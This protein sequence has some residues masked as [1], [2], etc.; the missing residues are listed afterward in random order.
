MT[1]NEDSATVKLL[2]DYQDSKRRVASLT[3][4]L[5]CKI[6]NIR[7][8]LD[9]FDRDEVDWSPQGF[10]VPMEDCH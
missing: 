9:H 3:H 5:N 6:E 10:R 7:Q 1:I 8:L 4:A 2:R